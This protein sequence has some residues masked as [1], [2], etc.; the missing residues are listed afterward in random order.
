MMRFFQIF[1][2]YFCSFLFAKFVYMM[3]FFQIFSAYFC[4]DCRGEK[5]KC[6]EK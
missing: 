2:A 4:R 1:S 5:Q 6:R 3:R